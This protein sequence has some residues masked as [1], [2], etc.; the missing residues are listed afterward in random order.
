MDYLLIIQYLSYNN[1]GTIHVTNNIIDSIKFNNNP[2]ELLSSVGTINGNINLFDSSSSI[3]FSPGLGIDNSSGILQGL[4]PTYLSIYNINSY[5]GFLQ[6]INGAYINNVNIYIFPITP[7]S[8]PASCFNENTQILCLDKQ[9]KLDKYMLIQDLR[10]ED[11]VKTYK[12]GYKSIVNIGKKTM[13]NNPDK[14]DSCMYKM[15]KT[16]TMTSDLILTGGHSIL[17]DGMPENIMKFQCH[18]NRGPLAK[19]DDKYLLLAFLSESFEKVIDTE[20]YTYYHLYLESDGDKTKRYGICSNGIMTE[21]TCELSF[22]R[23]DYT[24]L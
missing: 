16:D 11:L 23:N 7:P 20:K 15:K 21:T 5:T 9:T 18:L 12:H 8:P 2:T 19:I 13:I 10:K 1:S 3:I 24:L 14:W 22:L 17:L 4:P 6:D